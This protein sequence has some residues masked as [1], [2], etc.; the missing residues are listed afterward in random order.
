MIESSL[1]IG[2]DTVERRMISRP[3]QVAIENL[4]MVEFEYQPISKLRVVAQTSNLIVQSI[5]SFW[6]GV[7]YISHE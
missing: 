2:L 1:G 5:D 7:T 6:D 4:R 3:Y